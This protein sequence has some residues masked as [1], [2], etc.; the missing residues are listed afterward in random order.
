[1]F[2]MF[3]ITIYIGNYYLLILY[4]LSRGVVIP[5]YKS[6]CKTSML[7]PHRIIFNCMAGIIIELSRI[8]AYMN[9]FSMINKKIINNNG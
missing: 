8:F 4:L 2:F 7:F 6:S 3:L 9:I 5:F 1:M